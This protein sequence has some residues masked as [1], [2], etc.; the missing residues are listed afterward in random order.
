MSESTGTP[1]DSG[2]SYRNRRA[3]PRYTLIAAVE[4]VESV[5]EVRMSGRV[6]EISRQGCY[7][8][9]LNT[10]PIGTSINVRI[11]RDQGTFSSP[12]KIVYAQQGMGMGVAF[13]DT[14]AEQLK[15]L[16]VWL[17]ELTS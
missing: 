13:I 3:V 16:D 15:T 5:S 17:E 7:I 6:S 2:A 8:D 11:S 14:G 10:L 4:I 12:G 9:L 1:T